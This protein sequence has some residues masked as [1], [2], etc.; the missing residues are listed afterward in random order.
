MENY[1]IFKD[2][3][4]QLQKLKDEKDNITS[5]YNFKISKLEKEVNKKLKTLIIIDRNTFTSFI[6]EYLALYKIIY[7]DKSTKLYY[8]ENFN[9]ISILNF[10]GNINNLEY[11]GI[12][13]YGLSKLKAYKFIYH[14]IDE[15][16]EYI[17]HNQWISL[18]NCIL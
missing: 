13:E 9:I 5:A 10:T 17:F 14:Q 11:I 3:L 2:T 12:A 1:L 4:N 15:N 7:Y 16:V 8:D 18:D 6:K